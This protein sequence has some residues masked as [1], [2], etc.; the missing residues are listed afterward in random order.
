MFSAL[1]AQMGETKALG[2]GVWSSGE[3]LASSAPGSTL[4]PGPLTWASC[5]SLVTVTGP[6]GGALCLEPL[7]L[8]RGNHLGDRVT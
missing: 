1:V 2:A 5:L 4:P 8:S 3:R 7:Y 6:Q